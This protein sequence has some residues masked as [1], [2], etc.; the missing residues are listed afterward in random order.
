MNLNQ[1][2][3][4]CLEAET[5]IKARDMVEGDSN[6]IELKENMLVIILNVCGQLTF[7]V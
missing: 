2:V 1:I 3:E 7:Y 4:S 6:R 5:I